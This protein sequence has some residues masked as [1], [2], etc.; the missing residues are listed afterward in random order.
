M[1][2]MKIFGKTKLAGSLRNLALA[3]S[4]AAG[5]LF[6]CP[7]AAEEP[8]DRVQGVV[9]LES[10]EPLAG[11]TVMVEG[12]HMGVTT[13]ADGR[14]ELKGVKNGTVLAFSFIGM[15]PAKATVT[16][17]TLHISMKESAIAVEEVVA[18]GYSTVRKEELTSSVTRVD[19][20]DFNGGVTTSPINL[21]SG[22]V[23]GLTIRNTAGTDP[24]A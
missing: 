1:D 3:L 15:E 10:G 13:D 16:G 9:T 22:K 20:S 12:S 21:I 18:I 6:A 2:L 19:A 4:C 14:F 11:V 23:P 8:A 5:V 17:P 24:N 7:A